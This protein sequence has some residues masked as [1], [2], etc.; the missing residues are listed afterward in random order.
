MTTVRKR[1]GST[2]ILQVLLLVAIASVAYSQVFLPLT[3]PGGL[4]MM[5]GRYPPSVEVTLDYPKVLKTPLRALSGSPKPVTSPRGMPTW[6]SS[7]QPA[8]TC[9]YM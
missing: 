8:L 9:P 4:R 6:N 7:C 3:G 1:N 5:N 2:V